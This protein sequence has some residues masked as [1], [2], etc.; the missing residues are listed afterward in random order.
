MRRCLILMICILPVAAQEPKKPDENDK[1]WHAS[2][3]DVAT[4]YKTW[5]WLE[6]EMRWAPWL[7][8]PPMRSR[9]A[10]L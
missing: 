2:V 6:D 7:C 8:R 3:R 10:E 4:G 1:R 9:S 5:M